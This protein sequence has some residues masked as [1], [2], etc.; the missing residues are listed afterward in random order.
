MLHCSSLSL[1][2]L[3]F[4]CH[5]VD[6]PKHFAKMDGLEVGHHKVVPGKPNKAW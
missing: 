1:L 3:V 6:G 5:P 4:G 2:A